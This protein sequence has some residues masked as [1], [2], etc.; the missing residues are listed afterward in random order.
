MNGMSALIKGTSERPNPLH[1]EEVSAL[2]QQPLIQLRIFPCLD[3]ELSASR[4]MRNEFLLFISHTVYWIL[5]Q[6]PEQIK[7]S[8]SQRITGTA[9]PVFSLQGT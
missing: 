3:L 1:G 7:T 2:R 5:L 6:Q 9:I 4:T 8:T